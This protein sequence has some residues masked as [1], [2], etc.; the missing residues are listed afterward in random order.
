MILC[1]TSILA[2]QKK[3]ERMNTNDSISFMS[4]KNNMKFEMK[5]E[6]IP[7]IEDFSSKHE[8]VMN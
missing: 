5:D 4:K 7:A 2:M 8:F 3:A 1:E 6:F